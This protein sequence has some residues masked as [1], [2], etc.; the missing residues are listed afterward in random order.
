MNAAAREAGRVLRRRGPRRVRV[1]V[2]ITTAG[3]TDLDDGDLADDRRFW[4][5]DDRAAVDQDEYG[6][7]DG[8]VDDWDYE[9]ED[10]EYP[11]RGRL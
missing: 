3:G 2:V 8:E 1:R 4:Q 10:D 9:D 5:G 7:D 11:E 6:P